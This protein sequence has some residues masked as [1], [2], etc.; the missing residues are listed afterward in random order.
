ME[1]RVALVTGGSSG[2]GKSLC[3]ALSRKRYTTYGTSRSPQEQPEGYKLIQLDVTDGQ[4]IRACVEQVIAREGRLDVLINNAGKGIT[5]PMEEIP[6]E[7]LRAVFDTNYFGPVQMLNAALPHLRASPNA[8]VINVTSV[9]SFMGLPFRGAYSSS[10]AALHLATEAYRMELK[11]HGVRLSNVAPGDFAS[12]I[13]AGRYHAPASGQSPY[14]P[15]YQESLDL[16]NAH[17]DEGVSSDG[18]AEQIIAILEERDPKPTYVLGKALQRASGVIKSI[19][20]GKRY[21]KMLMKHFKL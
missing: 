12:N 8:H 9:A 15:Q 10:K 1:H 4:S 2:L 20:P 13:A 21:E 6:V 7:E 16:M 3:E 14:H 18:L 5:G 19:L 17:V 11:P